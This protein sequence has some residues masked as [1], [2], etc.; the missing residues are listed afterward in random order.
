MDIRLLVPINL[1]VQTRTPVKV[2]GGVEGSASDA[3]TQRCVSAS[4]ALPSTPPPTFTGVRVWTFKLIGTSKR[5]SIDLSVKGT[6]LKLLSKIP[7]FSSDT[8]QVSEEEA[9]T[10]P[11]Q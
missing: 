4:L 5:M 10:Y 2:G 7:K 1:K 3:E 11:S 6:F 8:S 9:Q